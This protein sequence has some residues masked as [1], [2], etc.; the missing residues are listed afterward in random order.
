MKYTNGYWLTK[1]EYDMHFAVQC[2]SA[3]ITED[4]LRIFCPCVPVQGR[5]DMLNHAALTVT[6]TAPMAD[7]IRVTVEHHRGTVRRGPYFELSESPVRPVITETDTEYIFQSG[8]AKAVVSKGYQN[9][10]VSY[11][12]DEA[13][14][15]RSEYHGMAHA[16]RRTD[17]KEY[18]IDS[19]NLDV[20]ER[21]YGLGERFTAYVK[22]GQTVDMWNGD[23]SC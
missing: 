16:W 12:G 5:G 4:A 17:G 2:G 18:M 1:P 22:N 3:A 23:G 7:V 15:T 14:L 13:L 19:L 9:W 21:V 11:L 8:R 20:G 6:F 10:R